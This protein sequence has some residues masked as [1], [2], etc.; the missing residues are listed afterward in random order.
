MRNK[1]LLFS[2][3]FFG[4]FSLNAQL[5][6]S[7]FTIGSG[8]DQ[9]DLTVTVNS[10]SNTIDFEMTGPAT[11]WFGVG[12]AATSMS[13]GSYGILASVS[14]GNPQEYT[15]QGQTT[16]SLHSTQNLSSFSSSTNSGRKTFTFSR[17]TNTGDAN[18]YSFPT[19]ATTINVIWAY[20]NSTTLA[21][22]A[23]RGASSM[24]FSNPCN[25][26]VNTM[27]IIQICTGDSAMIFGNYYSQSGT[28]HDTLQTTIGCDSV[29]EQ[30]LTVVQEIVNTLPDTTICFGDTITLFG[31][32]I[33]QNGTYSDTINSS[34]SCDSIVSITVNMISQID[35]TV[36]NNGSTLICNQFGLAYQWYDCN[37]GQ[38]LP[39]ET[40]MSFTPTQSGLY[41]VEIFIGDCSAMS[42]CHQV[43]I[44]GIEE[45]SMAKIQILPNPAKDYVEINNIDESEYIIEI[46]SIHGRMI[47]SEIKTTNKIN[48]SDFE[49]GI[50][51]IIIKNIDGELI[52]N[53]KI[54]KL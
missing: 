35:T 33:T 18:D 48:I 34:S 43:V 4:F 53:N 52:G 24:S 45:N 47:K 19:S 44:D 36:F 15:I 12:F 14:G 38:P 28:F 3:I 46:Y 37:T 20:G 2:I 22:H 5:N 9:I 13:S 49:K 17:A 29:I 6:Q 39:N 11:K 7:T 8:T 23:N 42:S 10:G 1:L 32:D 31:M 26:P 54:I 16:P 25:I 21:Q 41:K 30:E 40:N 50:Y 27:P 51:P